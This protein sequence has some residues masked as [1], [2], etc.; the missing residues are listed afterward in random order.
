MERAVF[1][2]N[3]SDFN[4]KQ[5]RNK[6]R[7]TFSNFIEKRENT[8]SDIVHEMLKNKLHKIE[9]IASNSTQNN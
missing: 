2:K 6:I 5:N 3:I 4:G 9:E 1:L 7:E 8:I